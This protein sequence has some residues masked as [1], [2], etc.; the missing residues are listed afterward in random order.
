MESRQR[1][2]DA[3]Q[4]HRKFSADFK[5]FALSRSSLDQSRGT[6]LRRGP[7]QLSNLLFGSGSGTGNVEVS[8]EV[9][10]NYN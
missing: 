5:S 9:N 7:A 6:P 2:E 4:I 1:E 3:R 8:F 10:Y